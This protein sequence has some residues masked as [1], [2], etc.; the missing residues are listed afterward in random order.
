MAD[1]GAMLKVDTVPNGVCMSA[2]FCNDD[3][4][5]CKFAALS[6]CIVHCNQGYYATED[7]SATHGM[8]CLYGGSS[9]AVAGQPA[10]PSR[11]EVPSPFFFFSFFFF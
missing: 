7:S 5:A 8:T 1:S 11:T 2:C 10:P 6:D 3:D 4:G 9:G